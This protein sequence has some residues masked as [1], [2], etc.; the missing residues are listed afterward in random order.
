[1]RQ[2]VAALTL[3]PLLAVGAGSTAKCDAGVSWIGGCGIS[4]S[5][6]TLNITGSRTSPDTHQAQTNENA[7]DTGDGDQT[8]AA[9]F[10]DRLCERS[11]THLRLCQ[12]ATTPADPAAQPL[13][14]P[15]APTI[16]ITDLATFAPDPATTVG[17]PGNV[18]IA[19]M[20][21]NFVAAASVATQSGTLFGIPLTVRFTPSGYD[22]H[23]GDGSSASTDTGGQTWA[24]LGQAQFT[25]TATSHVYQA[26]GTYFADVDVRYTAEIDLGLGWFP[27][28]GELTTDG[29]TSEIRIF[30]AHTALVARTCEQR[31][32]SPGC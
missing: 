6:T 14:S 25:P 16:T 19:G 9:P 30:E 23:Y 32:S 26:R 15:G 29:P 11:I 21:T 20:P 3:A 22:F 8:P 1:M 10:R 31:P 12:T 5:G 24:S 7:S 17:E 13:A 4:N 18:G 27:V 2:L 28:T